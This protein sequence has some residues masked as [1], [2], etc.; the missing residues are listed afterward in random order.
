MANI[1]QGCFKNGSEP[2]TQDY[3]WFAGLMLLLRIILVFFINQLFNELLY[4]VAPTIAALLVLSLRPYRVEWC[5]IVD[6]IF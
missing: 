5:N 1:T 4:I 2:G 6:G 3:R